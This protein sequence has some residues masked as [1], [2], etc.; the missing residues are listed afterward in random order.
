MEINTCYSCNYILRKLDSCPTENESAF[1]CLMTFI[2][3]VPWITS[4]TIFFKGLFFR[5][6]SNILMLCHLLVD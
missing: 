1:G 6:K 5:N 4:F 3:L 2:S